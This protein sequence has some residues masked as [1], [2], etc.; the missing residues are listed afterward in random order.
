MPRNTEDN[1]QARRKGRINEVA[2]LQ[3]RVVPKT[4][5]ET[6]KVFGQI[7]RGVLKNDQRTKQKVTG[8][9]KEESRYE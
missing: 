6:T 3:E 9:D 8:T 7:R 4:D 5:S 1:D 2:N